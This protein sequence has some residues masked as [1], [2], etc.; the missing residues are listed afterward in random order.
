VHRAGRNYDQ[1]AEDIS[2]SA[3][4]RFDWQGQLAQPLHEARVV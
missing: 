4:E 2:V 3:D 1:V